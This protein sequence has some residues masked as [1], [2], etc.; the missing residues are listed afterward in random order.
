MDVECEGPVSH[1]L[2]KPG[3]TTGHTYNRY[4][5]RRLETAVPD[6]KFDIFLTSG[7]CAPHRNQELHCQ[8]QG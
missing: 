1:L 8:R 6:A 3:Q 2:Q 5:L 7:L 4:H